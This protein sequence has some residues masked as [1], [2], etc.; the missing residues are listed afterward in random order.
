MWFVL[1]ALGVAIVVYVFA[2]PYLIEHFGF[3]KSFCAWVDPFVVS[4]LSKSRQIALARLTGLSGIVIGIMSQ[5]G[6]IPIDWSMIGDWIVSFFP[7]SAQPFV[8]KM[9]LPFAIWAYGE[10][11]RR[12]TTQPVEAKE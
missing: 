8:Q 11:M 4:W 7:L 9:I 6:D 1:A 10:F 3:W 2:R 5:V 12:V